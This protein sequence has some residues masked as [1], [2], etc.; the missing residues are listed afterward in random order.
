MFIPEFIRTSIPAKAR[1]TRHSNKLFENCQ[2]IRWRPRINLSYLLKYE[3][4]HGIPSRSAPSIICRKGF[5]IDCARGSRW[6]AEASSSG[7]RQRMAK[8]PCFCL[9]WGD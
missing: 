5:Y 3:V 7:L 1:P 9:R 6:R 2:E 8:H 4:S